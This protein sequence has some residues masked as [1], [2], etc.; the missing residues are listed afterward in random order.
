MCHEE[1]SSFYQKL[2]ALRQ[3]YIQRLPSKICELE[4]LWQN[5]FNNV[6]TTDSND[7]SNNEDLST[8]HR[9][10]HSLA[11]SSATHELSMVSAAARHLE[12]LL[13]TIIES[14]EPFD[15]EHRR[16]IETL[17]LELKAASEK[18]TVSTSFPLSASNCAEQRTGGERPEKQLEVGASSPLENGL[19]A[20]THKHSAAEQSEN[21]LIFLVE[22]DEDQSRDLELQIGHF[23]YIVKTF[24]RLEEVEEAASHSRPATIIMDVMFP[25]GGLAGVETIN[26]IQKMYNPPIP[27]M[28]ISVRG[29]I[30]TRLHA[31]R[32][33]GEAYFTKPINVSMLIDKLDELTDHEQPDPFHILIID[34]DP[35][36]VRFYE[37]V[38]REGGMVASFVTDPFQ[39]MQPLVDFR[40][41]LILMDLYM[42][43]CTGKELAA[44]IRQQEAYVGIP[45]VFL[46][47]ETDIDEQL[48]A[49]HGGG[50]DFLNKS[51]RPDHLISAIS[52]RATR[53]RSL[54]GSMI[55]DSLTGLLNH[56]ATKENLHREVMY[57]Q[58]RNAPF[59]FAMIDIDH[60]KLV[61]DTYGHITGDRVIKS[62]SRV[63]QQRLRKTDI[64]GRYGGEEF[65]VMLPDTDELDAAKVLDEIREDFAHIRQ[66]V[67]GSEF[68]VT[69]SC[70]V[71]DFPTFKD[72]TTLNRVADEALYH[73]KRTGRNRV[74]RALKL[75]VATA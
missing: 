21:R 12:V 18:H 48:R 63:L 42:P 23:G 59:A 34:D 33:G 3:S 24:Q 26:R 8:F 31:V 69:F 68:A 40:P 53:S 65:A 64:I 45:I 73:A 54:R 37:Q 10:V 39:I 14:Q 57:A 41:D 49:L 62:L 2:Q 70:G 74:V 56:T 71:A 16:R 6:T 50:D 13:R 46:S 22:D 11:G 30:E 67:E 43:G 36:M 61:N 25:E 20:R 19:H 47:T 9:A 28:F 27:V 44:V 72:A 4:K 32:A 66:R 55:R 5:I 15:T 17:L 38:V 29:D 1:H 7:D 35:E 60:F 58:R 52:I 75:G 51:I